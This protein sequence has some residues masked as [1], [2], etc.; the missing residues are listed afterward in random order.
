M[1]DPASIRMQTNMATPATILH[2]N[3]KDAIDFLEALHP[4]GPWHLVVIKDG[5]IKGR[6]FYQR[7]PMKQW[8]EKM[9]GKWNI[10][11][12]VNRL[13]LAPPKG[14]ATKADVAEALYSHVDVD[15][16]RGQTLERLSAFRPG[17]TVI[18]NSG[19]GY[20]AFWKF[21]EP[22]PDL[23]QVEDCNKRLAKHL[24]G[25]NCHNIDRI[26]RLPG[27]I[28]ILSKQKIARGRTP[29][30]AHVVEVDW[31]RAYK[32]SDFAGNERLGG[33]PTVAALPD[34][35]PEIDIDKLSVTI[36]GYTKTLLR[37]GDDPSA[38]RGSNKPYFK[39]RSEALWRAVREL[40]RAG[41]D[42]III[43]GLI[44][45]PALKISASVLDKPNPKRY[46]FKQIRWARAAVESEFPDT[47]KNGQLRP[48]L[49]NTKVALTKLAVE[50]RYDLFKML[51]LI[52][53][54][55]IETFVG[56]VSDPALLRLRELI[57][58]SFGFDP[59]TERVL[60]AVQTLANHAR[61]HPVRDYLDSLRW[62]GVPRID[63]WLTTYGSA[64]D[65]PFT[66]AVGALMLIAAVRRV[67]KPGC[68]FDELVVFES[69]QGTNKSQALQVIAV[70]S[71]WFSDN[72]P[73]G[74]NA[75]ETIEAMSGHWIIEASEMQG[76][77]KNDIEKIKA[78]LSRATDRARTAYARTVTEARR[79]C[80]VIG[81][82]NSEQYLRDLTGNRRFWPVRVERFDLEKLTR[83]RDQLWA[84]AAQREA[85]G[86]SIRLPEELWP[87]AAL[88]QQE[89]VTENPFVSVLDYILRD[90]SD[91]IG[92]VSE[93][94]I[95]MEGKLSSEDAWIAAGIRLGQ[96]SQ[97]NIELLG[98]AMREL[99]WERKRLRVGQ[100]GRSYMYVK[101][102]EPY[103]QINVYAGD[104]GGPATAHYA[105]TEPEP[106]F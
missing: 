97:Q 6:S 16:P 72:L 42:D 8:I 34:D 23:D 90:K 12:H 27:T 104:D 87:A 47:T 24:G 85:A 10:Y 46:A 63:S 82:T 66:R 31:S 84:E 89:R 43:A 88:E 40:V 68:K 59:T 15:D 94:G 18:T 98:Y 3:A 32:I 50:C 73:L 62:D 4:G 37:E 74:L 11:F 106:G 95:P 14:K 56:E 81:T 48:S 80:V 51:Y 105:T 38:P 44:L 101:G 28:N 41:C 52:N 78:F 29:A 67:R 30:L 61:Y 1:S 58:E 65:K 99:G 92:E 69:G 25:D 33:Y 102:K 35:V 70:Q 13:R 39:S 57:H 22:C 96:R 77:K 83:D 26:M 36:D 7:D 19:G 5:L 55:Q 71:E 86:A 45:N 64:E 17:P 60:T 49:P 53:G 2:P 79:Q 54:H 21:V 103:R 9:Q 100:S 75:R 20:Q 91:K 76:M 93:A